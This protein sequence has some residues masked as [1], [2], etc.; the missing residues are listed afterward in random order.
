ME[1]QTT[2]KTYFQEMWDIKLLL[3][4]HYYYNSYILK[5]LQ[6]IIFPETEHISIGDI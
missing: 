3:L 5:I 4:I 6:F 2:Y 1:A